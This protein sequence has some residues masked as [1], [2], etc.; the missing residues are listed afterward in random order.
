MATPTIEFQFVAKVH[1][2]AVWIFA[3]IFLVRQ[4]LSRIVVQNVVFYF[5]V[6]Y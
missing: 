1:A 2:I 4:C 6:V 5:V 3:I